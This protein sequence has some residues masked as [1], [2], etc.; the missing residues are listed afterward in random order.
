MTPSRIFD[1]LSLQAENRPNDKCL[2]DKKNGEWKSIST[3]KYFESVNFISAAL[4]EMG[5]K[6]QDK[7]ALISTTNRS[8]WS[9]MDMAILQLGA[10]TVPLYP[11]YQ[12]QR[13]TSTFSIIPRVFFVLF[14]TIRFMIKFFRSSRRS[15]TSERFMLLNR[16]EEAA[17]NWSEVD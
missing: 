2:N 4:I 11:Q 15:K 13:I 14:Q 3:Q 1:I 6:P 17:K 8:E 7:I 12:L 5:V 16:S 10:I 9:I